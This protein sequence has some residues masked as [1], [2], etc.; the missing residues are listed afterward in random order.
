MMSYPFGP[1][2]VPERRPTEP[3]Q[4]PAAAEAEEDDI[5]ILLRDPVICWRAHILVESGM[6]P[7]QSRALALDRRVD[8]RWVVDNLLLK[9]CDPAV[10]FDIASY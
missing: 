8:T 2:G 6:N 10:A 4:T 5:D 1:Q 9:G 7:R 3:E